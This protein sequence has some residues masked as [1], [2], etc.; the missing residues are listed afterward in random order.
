MSLFQQTKERLNERTKQ[1]LT[2]SFFYAG[3]PFSADL[4]DQQNYAEYMLLFLLNP[5]A[6]IRVKVKGVPKYVY[7]Q[8]KDEYA[9][10][11]EHYLAHKNY[12]LNESRE[13]LADIERLSSDHLAEWIDPR[14]PDPEVLMMKEPDDSHITIAV[15][16][17]SRSL[18]EEKNGSL[19]DQSDF[20]IR[21]NWF[22]LQNL[23]EYVGTKTSIATLA[24]HRRYLKQFRVLDHERTEKFGDDLHA[25]AIWFQRNEKPYLAMS[26]WAK[27]RYRATKVFN[28]YWAY[29]EAIKRNMSVLGQDPACA[30]SAALIARVLYPN[31]TIRCYGMLHPKHN[32]PRDGWGYYWEKEIVTAPRG[33]F[34]SGKQDEM[35]RKVAP[36]ANLELVS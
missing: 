34:K 3:I 32:L 6:K 2:S 10:F 8:S 9:K 5:Q 21:C 7:F 23:T 13:I 31:A 33:S 24:I 27:K 22:S 29:M 14:E 28:T 19:I 20:V 16:G 11:F 17:S 12:L 26:R 30:L 15:I 1:E 4:Q 36:L 35:T 25:D 18:L